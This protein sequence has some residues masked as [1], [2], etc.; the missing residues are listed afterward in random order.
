ME[1]ENWDYD[2]NNDDRDFS[3]LSDDNQSSLDRARSRWGSADVINNDAYNPKKLAD[4]ENSSNSSNTDD[5]SK[6]EKSG[7]AE[8][9]WD[10][11][12]TGGS[13]AS[14]ASAKEASST[15]GKAKKIAG[16]LKGKGPLVAIGGGLGAGGLIVG[17]FSGALVSLL[18]IHIAEVVKNGFANYR[19]TMVVSGTNTAVGDKLSSGACSNAISIKC[20]FKSTSAKQIK[21]LEAKGI[22][23][24]VSGDS[25]ITG[26]K[27]IS[28]YSY[29][30]KTYTDPTSLKSALSGD[31]KMR[32]TFDTALKVRFKTFADAKFKKLYNSLK[33]TKSG[34]TAAS[35]EGGATSEE[36]FED[37]IDDS[38]SEKPGGTASEPSREDYIEADGTFDEN[39]FNE[40]KNNYESTTKA[41]VS[42]VTESKKSIKR[43]ARGISDSAEFVCAAY[44]ISKIVSV[45]SKVIR[46]AQLGKFALTIMSISD[47]IKAGDAQP[48]E[49]E[50]VANMLT[51]SSTLTDSSGEVIPGSEGSATDSQ[52]YKWYAYG[53]SAP[54][55][56]ST[57]KYILGGG[58]LSLIGGFNSLISNIPFSTR[59]CKIMNSTAKD[60]GDLL[61]G[62]TPGIGWTKVVLGIAFQIGMSVAIQQLTAQAI[63]AIAGQVI[64]DDIAGQDAGNALFAGIGGAMSQGAQ[65]GGATLMSKDA[66]IAYYQ[67]TKVTIAKQA[68]EDRATHSPFDITNSN[69]FV[70]SIFASA[71]PTIYSSSTISTVSNFST[72]I[73][74]SFGSLLPA[75]H[76]VDEAK[77]KAGLE[78]CDDETY[79]TFGA[80]VGP[81]CTPQRGINRDELN[82]TIDELIDALGEE[83]LKI[84]DLEYINEN[85]SFEDYIKKGSGLDNYIKYCSNREDPIGEDSDDGGFF[86]LGG[87]TDPKDWAT[88]KNCV[89]SSNNTEVALYA[90]FVNRMAIEDILDDNDET[91]SSSTIDDGAVTDGKKLIDDFVTAVATGS[92]PGVTTTFEQCSAFSQWYRAKISNDTKEHY[93]DNG[94]VFVSNT[95]ADYDGW[96]FSSE[97]ISGSIFSIPGNS[98]SP[99]APGPYGHTGVVLEVKEDTIIIAQNN[100]GTSSGSSY[101]KSGNGLTGIGIWEVSKTDEVQKYG[102]TFAAYKGGS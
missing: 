98:G 72:L 30:G 76:A 80:A 5:I 34:K 59:T 7:T 82:M 91:T 19:N 100:I 11:K 66:A 62:L 3:D 47:K 10:N 86:G 87:I 35:E 96:E 81:D 88:G 29:E 93:G 12:F 43:A 45:S 83:N 102:W 40:A 94:G 89:Y 57:S 15:L 31:A 69:T 23:V 39:G 53:D 33:A 17:L 37:I 27:L 22:S 55:D 71:V 75:T 79:E 2:P 77:Y 95:V 8:S 14:R 73:K 16:K 44:G 26:R 65:Y 51:S 50:S 92:V 41:E 68:E 84:N 1:Q 90:S 101:H 56:S 48:E 99:W 42:Q 6:A 63:N 49:V 58:V 4:V 64:D 21:N 24:E 52:F 67:D 20:K 28:S 32:S 46:F 38:T 61:F 97:P 25:K 78:V 70:G 36:I 74:S 54:A 60:I 13:H 18:P 9:P 85:S